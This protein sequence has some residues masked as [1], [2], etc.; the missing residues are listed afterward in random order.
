L[1]ITVLSFTND[2]ISKIK[3]INQT[4]KIFSEKQSPIQKL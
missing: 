1:L 4:Q 3:Q 2:L